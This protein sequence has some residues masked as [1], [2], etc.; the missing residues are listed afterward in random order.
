MN[1]HLLKFSIWS[2]I[3]TPQCGVSLKSSLF[4][5]NVPRNLM[6][7]WPFFNPAR[8]D[9]WSLLCAPP[10][11]QFEVIRSRSVFLSKKNQDQSFNK[12]FFFQ[13]REM[14][15]YEDKQ[16]YIVYLDQ[17][18]IRIYIT[19]PYKDWERKLTLFRRT[20]LKRWRMNCHRLFQPV[21]KKEKFYIDETYPV[22]SVSVE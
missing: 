21:S 11:I 6:I 1:I 3:E 7:K 14:H 9:V 17:D 13:K 2:F 18:M 22:L 16:R 20:L 19:K 4:I 8:S 15:I 12:R 10:T 5:L